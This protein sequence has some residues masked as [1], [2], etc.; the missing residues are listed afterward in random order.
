[1]TKEQIINFRDNIAN[2]LPMQL[3]G[4]NTNIY[5]CNGF[6]IDPQTNLPDEYIIWDDDAEVF[7]DIRR[8]ETVGDS[9][10]PLNV[11]VA[12]YESIQNITVRLDYDRLMKVEQNIPNMTAE[13]K[14]NILKSFSNQIRYSNQLKASMINRP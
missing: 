10:Y 4:D 11:I 9:V 13:Q 1:M 14:S 12:T 2:G 6:Y 3:Y 7:Y 8:N 5:H